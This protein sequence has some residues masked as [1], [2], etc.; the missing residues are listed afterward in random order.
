[1]RFRSNPRVGTHPDLFEA[2]SS[3]V[4]PVEDVPVHKL[5]K[6]PRSAFSQT[7]WDSLDEDVQE[8][9]YENDVDSQARIAKFVELF[10]Q[11]YKWANEPDDNALL[12]EYGEDFDQWLGA[13]D[14]ESITRILHK[15]DSNAY[16]ALIQ[17]WVDAGVDTSVITDALNAIVG[18]NTMYDLSVRDYDYNSRAF[19]VQRCVLEQQ[20]YV[21]GRDIVDTAKGVYPDEL[22]RAFTEIKEKTNDAIELDMDEFKRLT[23]RLS[24]GDYY[25]YERSLDIGKA[26]K[27]EPRW[28]ALATALRE[29]L[30]PPVTPGEPTAL[31]EPPEARVIISF[32][33][34]WY[35]QRL[36]PEEIPEEGRRMRNCLRMDQYRYKDRVKDGEIWIVSLRNKKGKTE[37]S[38]EVDLDEAGKP[39]GVAQARG[40]DNHRPTKEQGAYA[41]KVVEALGLDPYID[42]PE[43]R[44]FVMSNPRRR[45]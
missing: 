3:V 18:D 21:Q 35:A 36:L 1:M 13:Q 27:A 45:R 31:S 2:V 15:Y 39:S 44:A 4:V 30:G 25:D 12:E 22:E 28:D 17:P 33:D 14:P 29:A 20:I 32:P 10:V 6:L 38:M 8:A 19:Y 43:L 9:I 26:I 16:D 5:I 37:L 34:G 23:T 40:Y 24:H 7:E 42:A 11:A 41:I